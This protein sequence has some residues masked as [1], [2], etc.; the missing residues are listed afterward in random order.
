MRL[1]DR[2][3]IIVGG[4][5]TPGE[6]IGNGRATALLFAREGAKVFVVDNRLE[7][8]ED[9]VKQ[10]TDEGGQACAFAADVTLEP[11]VEAMVSACHERYGRIDILHN[12]V[13]RSKGD[14][15]TVELTLEHWSEIQT[16][17]LTS[18]FLA[19]KH[20]LPIMREQQSGNIINIS[21]I[22]S[23]CSGQTLAYKTSKAAV[24]AMTQNLA[25]ENARYGVRVN[26]ILPG[27]MDT[28]MAIERR[29]AERNVE[30]AV[31][32]EER[33]RQVP[34]GRQ[35]GSGWDVGQA[36]VFLASD[37]A[38]FITGVCL[39]VDGGHSARIG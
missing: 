19:C 11:M 34:L 13:G 28:P 5:Q 26:A 25:L 33:D 23:L 20:T 18:Y 35:M 22:A 27:L 17:N 10:I 14:A 8:A 2:V 30:R 15:P 37:E 32:R 9:T 3:A 12:N 21:S 16:L 29:A 6:T 36:A 24:N 1:K 4:G 7:S 38:Q 39:P 31:V